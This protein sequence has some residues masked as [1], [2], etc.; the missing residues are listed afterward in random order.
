MACA[1]GQLGAA[2]LLLKNGA[3]ANLVCATGKLN[4]PLHLAVLSRSEA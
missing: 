4:S 3:D 1:V 2:R